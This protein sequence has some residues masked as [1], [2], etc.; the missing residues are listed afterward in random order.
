MDPFA[1]SHFSDHALLCDLKTLVAQDRT[2]TAVLLTR[3][4]EVDDRKLYL[5]EGYPS[6]FAY[7]VHELRLSEDAAY[8]RIHVARTAR[9]F[10]AILVALA[11][12]RVHLR[13]VLMLAPHLTSENA[14]ELLAAATH[15][16]RWELEQLLA[17]R[18]PRPDLPERLQ[19][20]PSP[21][22]PTLMAAPPAPG[23]VDQLAP[24]RV[25][26]IIPDQ[27]AHGHAEAPALEPTRPPAPER[28]ESPAPRPKMTP[29]APQR[30]GL[31]VTLDQEA[32]D[33]LRRAGAL[34]SHQ[35]PTG[36][37]APV[38][39][40]ALKFFV[41]HLEK[42]RFAATTRPGHSRRTGSARHI[43]AAVK[44]AVR[45]RDGDRCTFVSDSGQRCPA[46]T[47]LEFDHRIPV[48]RGGE[49]TVDNLRLACRA[50]NQYAAERTFGAGFIE[51]KRAE[52]QRAGSSG[53]SAGVLR[54]RTCTN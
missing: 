4:A 38:I 20:I 52:S 53:K 45:E 8:K 40:C 6:M 37:I 25:E 27:N 7:C 14:D 39:K 12:S 21:S 26:A 19:A 2:T 54:G 41:D 42:R 36:E 1:V 29:L 49:A 10:P 15:T 48:A 47:L 11:E 17:Q 51:R 30:F 13:A 34:M 31:Q 24:E 3:I 50:H 32:H 18:F 43:P 44:R 46:R 28:V 33:L 9:R 5:R 35:N 22:A 16:T 23:L